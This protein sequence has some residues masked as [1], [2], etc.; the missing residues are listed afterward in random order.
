[1]VCLFL[2][3]GYE[4]IEA[5]TPV[6]I[7]RRAKAE[8]FFVGVYSKTVKSARGVSFVCD[9]EL[10]E[11]GEEFFEK[12]DVFILPGGMPG[13]DNL[14]K[15]DRLKKIIKS[16]FDS[17]KL[18]CPICAAPVLLSRWDITKDKRITVFPGFEEELESFYVS[19]KSVEEDLNIISAKGAGC[20]LDFS[21]KI[22]E[23]YVSKDVSEKIAKAIQK[24]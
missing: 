18:I 10:R 2:A 9:V 21:L 6:D 14:E 11:L 22:A 15:S 4:E 17:G 5:I 19:G 1:M 20:A 7:L 8:V 23:R 13:V 16:A 3:D 24:V 12:V